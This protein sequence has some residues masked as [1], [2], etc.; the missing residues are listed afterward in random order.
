MHGDG[1]ATLKVKTPALASEV[2]KL[3]KDITALLADN[4]A[5]RPCAEP[6][7]RPVRIPGALP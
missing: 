3:I 1:H 4:I 5:A 6:A 7:L 2:Q